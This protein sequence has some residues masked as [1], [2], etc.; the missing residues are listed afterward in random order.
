MS[1]LP[2]PILEAIDFEKSNEAN[3]SVRED[4]PNGTAQA[5]TGT[6]S[7]LRKMWAPRD[8][9]CLR[10]QQCP[11]SCIRPKRSKANLCRHQLAYSDPACPNN[12]NTAIPCC[13]GAW[14]KWGFADGAPSNRKNLWQHFLAPY[15]LVGQGYVVV[16]PDYAG[17]GVC[18]ATTGQPIAHEYLSGPSQ[19]ND[20]VYAVQAAQAG[21]KE[22]SK[23]F[24]VIGHS[25]G[26]G[27][28]MAHSR[29]LTD[30]SIDRGVRRW[31]GSSTR[32][33]HVKA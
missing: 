25:Q 19:A 12:T 32:T 5:A 20:I 30:S 29:R 23:D 4:A 2:S 18:K 24:V 21:F 13:L 15:Q 33:E 1:S 10:P 9:L 31:Y 26:G 28:D 6:I 8:I 27:A 17:L 22:L 7:R 14:H 11:V 16:A 3:G